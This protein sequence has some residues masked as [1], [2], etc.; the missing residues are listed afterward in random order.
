[1]LYYDRI[2][3]R[4]DITKNNNNKECIIC[5]FWVFNHSFKFQDFACNG[6]HDLAILITNIRII[7]IMAIKIV[8]CCCIIHN[9]KSEAINILKNLLL[10]I[11]DI[12]KKVLS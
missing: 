6:C 10:K 11:V 7:A 3:I 2:D 8:Y 4:P 9:S 12:Y 1:M 5:N